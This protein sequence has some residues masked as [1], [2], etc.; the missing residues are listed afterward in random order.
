MINQLAAVVEVEKRQNNTKGTSKQHCG[1]F[2]FCMLNT[3]NINLH[4]L[5]A[6]LDGERRGPQPSTPV[7][8]SF[9]LPL[10]TYTTLN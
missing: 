10:I 4:P 8:G 5:E 2:H 3:S 1:I 7:P 9:S 6:D